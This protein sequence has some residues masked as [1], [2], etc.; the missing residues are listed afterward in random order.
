M[1]YIRNAGQ[2][3]IQRQALVLPAFTAVA[4]HNAVGAITQR[5]GVPAVVQSEKS[6]GS[7]LNRCAP[8][9]TGGCAATEYH[10][11]TS[12]FNHGTGREG[13]A[14]GSCVRDRPAGHVRV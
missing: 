2:V 9:F 14:D 11:G 7:N 6:G 10:D 3:R 4:D 8:E 5:D 12:V 13:V 1:E